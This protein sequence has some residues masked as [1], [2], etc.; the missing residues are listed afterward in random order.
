MDQNPIR[1]APPS[2]QD[3]LL[4]DKLIEDIAGQSTRMDDLARQLITLELAIPGVF[5][6]AL[7]LV[8]GDRGTIAIGIWLVLT[9]V[10]NAGSANAPSAR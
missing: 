7:K 5:A 2:Q 6:T 8:A 10:S 9:P 1:T 4:R 3:H